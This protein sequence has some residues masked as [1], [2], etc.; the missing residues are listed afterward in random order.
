[1]EAQKSRPTLTP[2]EEVGS[3]FGADACAPL[4]ASILCSVDIAVNG[5]FRKGAWEPFLGGGISSNLRI[6][7]A[8]RVEAGGNRVEYAIGIIAAAG[9]SHF[10]TERWALELEV[11]YIWDVWINTRAGFEHEL[12]TILGGVFYF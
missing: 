1:M 7:R 3:A 4:D 10:F 12:A 2:F 9:F 11:A 5:L 6:F 8:E